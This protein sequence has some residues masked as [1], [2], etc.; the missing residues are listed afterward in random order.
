MN[1]KTFLFAVL[2][3]CLST[4]AHAQTVEFRG[5][6]VMKFQKNACTQDGWPGQG[7]SESI[8][9]RYRPGGVGGNERNDRFVVYFPFSSMDFGMVNGKFTNA[10]KNTNSVYQFSKAF[11]QTG[12]ITKARRVGLTPATVKASTPFVR[13]RVQLRNFSGVQGCDVLIDAPLYKRPS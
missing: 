2:C 10:F 12:P 3:M 6:G 7:G 4:A 8:N 5:G 13:I 1:I 11:E 9:V